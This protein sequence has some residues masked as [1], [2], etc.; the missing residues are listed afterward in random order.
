[1]RVV[2]LNKT[3]KDHEHLFVLEFRFFSWNKPKADDKETRVT[4]T[5]EW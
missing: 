3:W 1:M 4:L 5:S 2:L